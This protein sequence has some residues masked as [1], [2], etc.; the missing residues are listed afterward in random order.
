MFRTP[1]DQPIKKTRINSSAGAAGATGSS[2]QSRRLAG[3]EAEAPPPAELSQAGTELRY[4]LARDFRNGRALVGGDPTRRWQLDG[5]APCDLSYL[6]Q[7]YQELR[8]IH[9][10][11]A[12]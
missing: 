3:E 6:Q 9:A 12:H 5:Q 2:R 7:T 4:L 10:Q 11:I 1:T 8:R